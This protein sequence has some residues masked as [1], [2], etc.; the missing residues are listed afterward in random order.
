MFSSE[1]P[2]GNYPALSAIDS[3]RK[4]SGWGQG[5]GGWNDGT[6]GG[7][8]DWLEV[9]FPTTQSIDEIDVYTL[10]N[11]WKTA[12]NDPDQTTSATGDGILDF[13]VEYWDGSSWVTVGSITNNDLAWRKFTF[14]PV[15]TTKIHVVIHNSR[16][17][18]S[19]IV[20]LEAYSHCP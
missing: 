9:D 11:G 20:E 18:Y 3:D 7:Y 14:S 13:D 16:S 6:R 15:E 5:T 8:D 1:H 19:R 4:G 10:Q 17:N 12:I 2:S